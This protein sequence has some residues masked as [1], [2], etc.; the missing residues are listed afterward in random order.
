VLGVAGVTTVVFQRLRQPVVLGYLLAGMIVGPHVAVPIVANEGIVRTLSE[1]GV[2]LLMFAL[3]LEFSLQKLLRV[4][5]TAALT[6]AIQ[7]GVAALLGYLAARALGWTVLE[8]MFSGAIVAVSSTT[9]IAKVFDEERIGGRLRELVVGIL[10]VEDLIAIAFMA[11]LTGVASGAGLSAGALLR[12]LGA[13]ALFLVTLLGVGIVV[14]PRF[15]RMVA[16]LGRPET[17]LVASVGVCFLISYV[18]QEAGYSVALGAFLAGSLVAE[19]GHAEKIEHL[20]VPVRDVFAAIFFVSV[21]MSFDPAVVAQHAVAIG[22]LTVIVIAGKFLGV[23]LGAFFTGSG[24]RTAVQSGMSLGQIGEFSFIIAVTGLSLGATREF[25]YP[26][27]VAVSAITTLTTPWMIRSAEPFARYVDHKLPPPLQTFTTLYGAW[28]ER[29]S[30]PSAPASPWQRFARLLAVDSLAL[31]ALIAGVA[32]GLAPAVALIESRASISPAVARALLVVLACAL[33]LPLLIG[34]GRSARRLAAVLS[35]SA[36]PREGAG[37]D[38]DAAPRRA[39]EL[40]L[41]FAS[42]LLAGVLVLALTQPFLPAISTP[43]VLVALSGALAVAVWR[44]AADLDSHVR[45]GAQA[46]LETLATYATPGRPTSAEARPITEIQSL[47]HGLGEPVAVELDAS[48]PSVGRS[49]A[50]L[51]LRGLT[52]ATVLAIARGQDSLPTP[53][54]TERLQT[55]DVLALAGTHDAVEAARVILCGSQPR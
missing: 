47:L 29:L 25:L 52:G 40:T 23:S 42:A 22:V 1:L 18:A 21:G 28:L 33:A 14:V 7:S 17:T 15:I 34:I 3:G 44:G 31:A 8:A 39:L 45:A 16:K 24:V 41:R 46:V 53:A 5:P 26:V 32:A 38:L 9:I 30:R 36:L 4:G 54:A 6:A 11:A 27:T 55:G 13:L 2:V 49:L 20:V 35:L 51:D 12:T 43:I 50:E 19:S 48:C 37:A 10:L